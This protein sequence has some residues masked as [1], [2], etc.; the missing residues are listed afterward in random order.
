MYEGKSRFDRAQLVFVVEAILASVLDRLECGLPHE[1]EWQERQKFCDPVYKNAVGLL[2]YERGA[3]EQAGM[4]MAVFYAQ[5]TNDG[6]GI[7]DALVEADKFDE[8]VEQW[9]ANAWEDEGRVVK[10]R[11]M[12]LRTKANGRYRLSDLYPDM[13]NAHRHAEAFVR[14]FVEEGYLPE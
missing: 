1:I 8:A 6:L 4:S 7:Y 2:A 12:K 14:V 11:Q 13:P 3:L 5:L 9:V 10:D